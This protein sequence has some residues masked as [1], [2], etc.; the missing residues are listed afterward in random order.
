MEMND[1]IREKC[2][3]LADNYSVLADKYKLEDNLMCMVT[4]LIFTSADSKADIEKLSE[5]RKILKKQT[6]IFSKLRAT[7]ELAV[8]G[9]MA[10]SDDPEKYI[11]DVS[12]VYEKTGSAKLKESS[13]VVPVCLMIC[14]L[15]LMEDSDS[16]A[17]KAKEIIERMKSAH[18][19]LTTTED[20]SFAMLLALSY[21]D[22]DTI[23]RDIEEG[24]DYLKNEYKPGISKDTAQNLCEVL[25]V[26]YGDMRSKCDKVARIYKAFKKR[27]SDYGKENELTA[28]ASLVDIDLDPETLAGEI[29]EAAEYLKDK[30]GFSDK[31]LGEKH[32]LMYA[33][34]LIADVYGRNTDLANNP[35]ISSTLS[36]ITAKRI[37]A[38]I[39]LIFNIAVNV[40]PE[41]LAVVSESSEEK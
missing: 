25:A 7:M 29:I 36:I 40:L 21:K 30:D 3:L 31:I 32:R 2:D 14:D 12:K 26:T 4:G 34:L 1:A 35:A 27:R 38:A 16:I 5:C 33:T 20:T 39:S 24:C 17:A 15:G 28:L 6:G 23:I 11:A 37:A 10:L 8:L 22:V 18:P 13:Y 41:V 9:K 19:L